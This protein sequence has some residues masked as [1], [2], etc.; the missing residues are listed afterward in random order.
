MDFK[1]LIT[2]TSEEQQATPEHPLTPLFFVFPFCFPKP[3][4]PKEGQ[5]QD[6][7]LLEVATV[8][9]AGEEILLFLLVLSEL[10]S[11]SYRFSKKWNLLILRTH[12][13]RE[14]KYFHSILDKTYFQGAGY[15]K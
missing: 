15:S 14:V 4:R 7:L 9:F 1:K 8:T 2:I 5:G 13:I 12:R 10:R 6:T 3:E 11:L